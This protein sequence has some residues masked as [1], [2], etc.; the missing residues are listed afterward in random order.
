MKALGRAT[1]EQVQ[2]EASARQRAVTGRLQQLAITAPQ[3]IFDFRDVS[4]LSWLRQWRPIV[5]VG[6]A[7]VVSRREDVLGVLDD[8]TTFAPPYTTG[9]ASGFVLGLTGEDH[10]RHHRALEGLLRSGD[11]QH[12]RQE[13]ADLATAAVASADPNGMAVGRELVRPVLI[14]LVARYVG[15]GQAPPDVLL[16]W[17]RAIFQDIFLNNANL[18]QIHR[19]GDGAAAE[20]RHVVERALVERRSVPVRNRPDDLLTRIMAVER[21]PQG[22][23]GLSHA[24]IV[25]T[26]IGLAIGWFW[27]ATKA[28]MVAIDGLLDR[29][30][31][32]VIATAAA[33][34][35]DMEQLQRVLWEVL[36]FRP[37]QVGLPRTC[38]DGAI[39]GRGTPYETVV[40]PHAFVLA[41]TH[42]AMWDDSV[43]PDPA[44][45]DVTRSDGQYLVFGS[46]P[47]RCMGEALV[48]GQLPAM[49]APLLA[50]DGLTRAA[51]RRGRLTWVDASPDE[52]WVQFSR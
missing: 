21:A 5:R 30:E 18:S 12:L 35:G 6:N 42:S 33:R 23:D 14:D 20:V 15:I 9:L 36:R 37:V 4:G 3:R 24:E 49:V 2:S 43:V 32:L 19:A 41:G 29:R 28:A 39:L 40:P 47:H 8:T 27:H 45:F 46:G 13:M 11:H 1:G 31:A 25:D 48:R 44:R 51:G 10:R 38:P 50:V 7:V 34:A 17:S 52:L 22:P 16:D 26:V